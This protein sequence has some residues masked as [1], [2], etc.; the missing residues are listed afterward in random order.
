MSMNVHIEPR[1]EFIHV[2]VD[3][4][5]NLADSKRY[6][7]RIF[8]ACSEHGVE[9]ILIDF[10]SATGQITIMERY[11]Y[12]KYLVSLQKEYK[13]T[14]GVLVRPAFVGFEPLLDRDRFGLM[15]GRQGGGIGLVTDD[16]DEA[17]AWLKN[18]QADESDTDNS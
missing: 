18:D 15:V 7:S 17:M 8:D 16:I 3:G 11:R 6:F 5:I 12:A 2:K 13:R 14:H 10:R 9:K 4:I 1:D